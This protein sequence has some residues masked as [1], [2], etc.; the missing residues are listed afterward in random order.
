MPD[1]EFRK[2]NPEEIDAAVHLINKVYADK[3]LE[4]EMKNHT[5]YRKP[6]SEGNRTEAEELLGCDLHVA[7]S[8]DSD[9]SKIIGTIGI[10]LEEIHYPNSYLRAE[11]TLF[12]IKKEYKGTGIGQ[13]LLR[14]AEQ[15]AKKLKADQVYLDAV[16]TQGDLLQYYQKCGYLLTGSIDFW[17]RSAHKKQQVTVIPLTKRI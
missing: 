7:V 14:Y 11:I 17:S 1:P 15:E 9:C 6:G 16:S 4:M 13:K 2:I 5:G 3:D 12:S 10:K 8:H